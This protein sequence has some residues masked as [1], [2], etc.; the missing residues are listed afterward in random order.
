[1]RF[2]RSP[3]AFSLL[4]PLV[5]FSIRPPDVG[6]AAARK[7]P[8]KVLVLQ[9]Y[10]QGPS[11][12]RNVN[13]GILS[14]LDRSADFDF[15]LRFEYMNV[16]DVDPK[17]YPEIYKRRLGGFRFDAVLCAGNPA[18]Q[19]IVENRKA[20]FDGVPIVFCGVDDFSRELLRGEPDITGVTGNLDFTGTLRLALRLHPGTR[21]VIVL[22]NRRIAAEEAD[23]R[24]FAG[25]I[26]REFEERKVVY[27]ED[28]PLDEVLMLAEERPTQ[29]IVFDIAFLTDER[30]RP[31]PLQTS[32]QAASDALRVPLYSCWESLLGSGI[33]GGSISAG[34]P[35]GETAARLALRILKG[36]RAGSIP[37]VTA[38]PSRYMF[39]W[40]QL[41]R[42]HISEGRLP[43]GSLLI[44]KPFTFYSR[45]A[46]YIW[47][48]AVVVA[49]LVL[50][51]ALS[52]ANSVAQR[53]MKENIRQSEER[54]SLALEATRSGI[55]EYYPQT[56]RTYYGPRWFA[57]LGYAPCC[58]PNEYAT[59]ADLLHPE[60]RAAAEAELKSH[61]EEGTDFTMEFRMR[62]ADGGWRWISSSGKVV[63]RGADGR[64]TRIVGTHVD[65]TERKEAEDAIKE[66]ARRYRFLYEKSPA[67][68]IILGPG[69][70]IRDIN[71]A[72]AEAMGYPREEVIGRQALEYVLPEHRAL[73]AEEIRADFEGLQTPPIE[74]D[75]Q[76]KDGSIHTILFS[77]ASALLHEGGRVQGLMI[78]GVDVTERKR[79]AEQARTQQRQLIQADKMA[80]LGVLVSGVAHEINNPNNY[81]LLNGKIC[82]RVWEDIQPIL[83]E[84]YETHGDL[85]I[86]GMPYSAAQPQIGQLIGGIHEGAQRIKKIVQNLRDFTRRDAGDMTKTVDVNAVVDS[87]VTL[88]RNLIDKSTARFSTELDPEAPPITG[89]FQQLEQVIINLITNACQALERREQGI[90][91]STRWSGPSRRVL[92]QVKDEGVGIPEENMRRIM[93]P[94]FTTKQDKGGTG[95]GLSISYNIVK[96]HGGE[97]SISSAPGEGTTVTVE[98][99]QEAGK[100]ETGR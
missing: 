41:A 70:A 65:V 49:I 18:L 48:A 64:V 81:I 23:Y 94:F 25:L 72:F 100:T 61:V 24:E 15:A 27:W 10:Q 55:W 8:R 97:L 90:H 50:L 19:F 91:L 38:T 93:D 86:A 52:F 13:D 45:Y 87:S 11:W 33:V 39:D 14:I 73:A 42:F 16:L 58:L 3:W 63:E 5:L 56:G 30:G 84:Q 32:T 26:G 74:L 20:F 69:G 77:G 6:A 67:L 60:D 46:A 96:N 71:N 47:I 83:R 54:L 9:S 7:E 57:M 88:M 59:W 35:Q 66:S 34:F 21:Q 68:S 85:L 44:N 75:L 40:K 53:R 80:S 98:L 37:V 82:S 78:T 36:E 92:V 22:A 51:L 76:A 79:A 31:L 4:L 89:N 43:K 29:T 12:V 1:M 17:G 95:L 2:F 62:A 99:P 28:P